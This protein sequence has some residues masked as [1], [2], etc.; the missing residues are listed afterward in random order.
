MKELFIA[1][2]SR[3]DSSNGATVR[4]LCGS[5]PMTFGRAQ[6]NITGEHITLTQPAGSTQWTISGSQRHYDTLTVDF[7][8]WSDKR[9]PQDAETVANAVMR[10]YDHQ[11]LSMSSSYTMTEATRLTPAVPIEEPDEKGWHVVVS[12]DYRVGRG[13]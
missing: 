7:N 11:L 8:I 13:L 6:Q 12:Y 5:N 10:L 1:I 2:K 4:S 3:Y 9:S